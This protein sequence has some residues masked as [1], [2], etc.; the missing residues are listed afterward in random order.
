MKR[1]AHGNHATYLKHG[2]ELA[3]DFVVMYLV[4][5]TM[6]ASLDH[7]RFNINNVY[8]TLMMVTPM[9]LFMLF[10]MWDMFPSKRLNLGIAGAAILV[11]VASFFA[12]RTQSGVGNEQFLLSMIPHHSGAILMCE[13][14]SITDPEIRR[15]CNGIIESQQREIDQMEAILERRY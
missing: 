2:V 6:I 3:A 9:A 4:M 5:Y 15:L 13:K 7:L 1:Q 12:M 8:M 11:F 10:G 14:A